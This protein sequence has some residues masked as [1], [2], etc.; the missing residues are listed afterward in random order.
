MHTND[1]QLLEYAR[2]DDNS[3]V[4]SLKFLFWLFL[5]T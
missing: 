5:E 2:E 1:M 3:N 4:D